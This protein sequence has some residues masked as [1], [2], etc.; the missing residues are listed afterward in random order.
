MDVATNIFGLQDCPLSASDLVSIHDGHISYFDKLW[1]RGEENERYRTGENITKKQEQDFYNQGRIPFPSPITS[2]K[3]TRIIASERN[4]RTS[5]KAQALRPESEMKAEMLTLRLR[6]VER[7]SNLEYVESEIF[8]SGV[9]MIYGV[10]KITLDYDKKFNRIIKII[11]VDY[12]NCIWDSNARLYD[13]SDGAFMAERRMVYRKDIRKDYGDKIADA[14]AINSSYWGREVN[15]YWGVT[16]KYGHRDDDI[17]ILFEHYQKVLRDVY[18]VVWEDNVVVKES[19]K[20]EAEKTLRLLQIPYLT[21][22][23]DPPVASVEKYTE[24]GYDKYVF[25]YNTILEYEQTDLEDFPYCVYQ[26]FNFKDK[27][28]C[29]TDI[30]KY[31]NKFMDKLISQI[32]YAFGTDLKNGWEIVE[33]WLAQGLTLEEATRRLKDGIP[34]P[35]LRPGAVHS[36]PMKQANPQWIQIYEILAQEVT[37]IAGGALFAGTQQGKQRESKESIAMK[38]RQQELVT[39]LFIDN[40]RRWKRDLM[41]KVTWYI[42]KYDT[43]KQIIRTEGG[44]LTPEMVQLLQQN[45]IYSPSVNQR[46]VGYL[47]LNQPDNPESWLNDAEVDITITESELSETARQ[48]RFDEVRRFAELSPGSI[49]P[50]IFLEFSDMDYS[51]KERI[52]QNWEKQQQQ[53]QAMQEQ[54][55]ANENEDRKIEA[56]KTM[57]SHQ[58]QLEKINAGKTVAK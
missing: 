7:D 44:N 23:Q 13:K 17:I 18:C 48:A 29:M 35:T 16:D 43:E 6:K 25:T 26:S 24:E 55:Q 41:R 34:I 9:A 58:Q 33:P 27:I 40:L 45:G 49:T 46:G 14:I 32:D 28:W 4:S 2:D 22:D 31:K 52:K 42:K 19:S 51:V 5:A 10:G 30:L 12:K 39:T 15:E 21:A 37:E 53:Q 50:D 20:A 1:A 36:I 3:I 56:A 57:L 54:Q 38:L 11:D 47:S 8:E